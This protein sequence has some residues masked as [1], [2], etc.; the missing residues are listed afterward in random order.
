[1]TFLF[2]AH[3]INNHTLMKKLFLTP[4]LLLLGV[5]NLVKAQQLPTI[6]PQT[7]TGVICKDI[8]FSIP[9]NTTGSFEVGNTFKVQIKS[10]NSNTWVD[11][12]TQD[13]ASP[14]K[15]VVPLSFDENA[16]Y[17]PQYYLRIVSSKPVVISSEI[18]IPR[19][20]TKAKIELSGSPIESINPYGITQ[21][22]F[23]GKGD[24]PI[25]VVF[26]DSSSVNLLN[27]YY[28]SDASA[29]VFPAT[30]KEYKIAYTENICGRGEGNGSLKITVN[31]IA[32][33]PLLNTNEN[34]CVGGIL[35]IPY[36]AGGK[37]NATNKFRIGL[38]DIYGNKNEYE[39]EATEKDGNLETLIPDFIPVGLTY[40][41]RIL[42]S[43]PKAISK[44]NTDYSILIGETPSVEVISP[45]T[46][47]SWGNETEIHLSLKGIAP[48][49]VTL[50][51]GTLVTYDY[52]TYYSGNPLDFIVPVK[53]NKTQDFYV[54]SFTSGCGTGKKGSNIMNVVVEAG[55]VIDSLKR[56]LKLC[57][58]E[59]FNVKYSTKG[60]FDVNKVSAFISNGIDDNYVRIKVPAT[61]NNGIIKVSLPLNLFS[62]DDSS[63]RNSDSFFFGILKENGERVYSPNY[64]LIRIKSLPKA[65][66]YYPVSITLPNKGTAIIPV[67]IQGSGPITITFRD[68]S[69]YTFAA[70]AFYDL[71]GREVPIPVINDVIFKIKSVS[72]SCGTVAI[73]DDNVIPVNI[74]NV[75][76]RDIVEAV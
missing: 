65:Y 40:Q 61:F 73:E 32:L 48:W 23:Q 72:N 58:G 63:Y 51:D 59:S 39:L 46:T 56:G 20:Y 44:W 57:L 45:S 36:V 35:K 64:E 70:D 76:D 60:N 26:N 53:P 8:P 74:R 30:T 75:A 34:V 31:E 67:N 1:L 2:Y 49:H 12:V 17:Y 50:N 22:N 18:T 4:M 11:F 42:S 10:I 3:K 9:F 29:I 21:L 68:S 43:S 24:M 15:V 7:L 52:Y 19:L 41:V 13:V 54:E 6:T 14:L 37:F 62:D 69:T 5:F 28:I 66:F 25:K 71:Y 55:I 27:Y 47:I 16:I 33:K 38:R